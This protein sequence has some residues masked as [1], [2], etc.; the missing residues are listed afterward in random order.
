MLAVTIE[1]LGATDCT[2]TADFC[3]LIFTE[4]HLE[5]PTSI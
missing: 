2:L 3:M 4:A 5:F 1:G